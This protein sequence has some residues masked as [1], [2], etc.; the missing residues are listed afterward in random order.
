M[1]TVCVI[2]PSVVNDCNNKPWC[3][4]WP[5]YKSCG[6]LFTCGATS[7]GGCDLVFLHTL[8][9]SG[10]KE[11]TSEH[12]TELSLLTREQNE[13]IRGGTQTVLQSPLSSHQRRN[14]GIVAVM[15]RRSDCTAWGSIDWY[16]ELHITLYGASPVQG[17]DGTTEYEEKTLVQSMKVLTEINLRTLQ[18]KTFLCWDQVPILSWDQ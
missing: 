5:G 1:K 14:S 3:E 12:T 4:L 18:D 2:S 15:F 16:K 9:A 11:R 7:G 10:E 6:C 13:Y 8:T 17:R